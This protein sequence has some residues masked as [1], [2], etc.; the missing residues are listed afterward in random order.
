[1]MQAS[2]TNSSTNIER[3]WL[4]GIS[5]DESAPAKNKYER[6]LNKLLEKYI[7]FVNAGKTRNRWPSSPSP[8]ANAGVSQGKDVPGP[9]FL[10]SR[11]KSLL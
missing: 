3:N 11:N 5:V 10:T 8:A 2:L 6:V 4:T 7:N 1:M 9:T